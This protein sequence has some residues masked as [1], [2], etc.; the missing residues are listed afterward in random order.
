VVAEGGQIKNILNIFHN[1]WGKPGTFV[2]P[3]SVEIELLILLI[4]I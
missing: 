2:K 1:T 3:V 4:G